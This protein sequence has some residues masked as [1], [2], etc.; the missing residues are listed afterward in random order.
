[1]SETVTAPIGSKTVTVCGEHWKESAPW[2]GFDWSKAEI[3]SDSIWY[4]GDYHL[5]VPWMHPE[6]QARGYASD[7]DWW[8]IYRVRL[9]RGWHSFVCISGEWRV[10]KAAP[11]QGRL[12]TPP[13]EQVRVIEVTI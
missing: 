1:M 11:E 10:S 3:R 12:G 7:P 6:D 5:G 2:G 4:N 9:K 13:W 8:G